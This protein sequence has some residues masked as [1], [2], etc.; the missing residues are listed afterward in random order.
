MAALRSLRCRRRRRRAVFGPIGAIVG[1]IAGAH[2]A[3]T[4]STV[5]CS[6]A[7]TPSAD[8]E[9][10]RLSDLD[11][12]ASTEGAPIPRVYGRARLSGQVIWA[13][14]LEEVVSTRTQ[15]TSRAAAAR[16]AGGGGGTSVTTTT[17]TY[18][19]FANLAVGA[20]RGPDRA[21]RRG[22][23]PTASRSICNGVTFRV[24][25]G[26]RDADAGSADRRQGGQRQR[27]GLSRHRLCRVR[28]AA[29]WRISAI[30]F[31]NCRSRSCARSD[32]LENA[33]AR[34]DADSRLDR[35]R[36]RAAT[37][38]A[39]ARARPVGAG[40]PPCHLCGVGC[41]RLA[42]RIAGGLSESRTRRRSSWPGSATICA[43][44][45]AGSSRASTTGKNRRIRYAGRS[46]GVGR[47]SAYLVSAVA[48]RAAFG[49][50]PSDNSVR[51]SDRRTEGAR[52]EGHALSVRDDGHPG[53]Q[54]AARSVDRRLRR[55]RLIPGAAGSPAIPRPDNPARRTARR[56][57]AGQV[58]AFFG[59][60]AGRP[61]GLT[62]A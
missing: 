9:G 20:V 43:P 17:T 30:A 47:A 2:R 39:I 32:A 50:T 19:Y 10:P 24:Y 22:S 27:A 28:A 8:C 45:H 49:G 54:C 25:R 37:V 18:S 11:V 46:P 40:E 33:S 61:A 35:V 26:E 29:G 44:A 55:S 41:R 38:R 13:T 59:G 58:E 6:A 51:P 1:R 57:A 56:R 16:A 23:G 15:T 34:G 36:L 7:A 5:R 62:G 52:L 4:R 3:A 53:G 31:R 14:R 48:G 12:M 42:R 60:T 21:C